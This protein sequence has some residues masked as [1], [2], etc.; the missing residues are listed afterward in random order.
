MINQAR[1]KQEEF[2]RRRQEEKE[3]KLRRE[4][5]NEKQE[6]FWMRRELEKTEKIEREKEELF[7]I[8]YNLIMKKQ[9]EKEKLRK[10]RRERLERVE[11]K[12]KE[13]RKTNARRCGEIVI[14]LV[15]TMVRDM[16]EKKRGTEIGGENM[17][18]KRKRRGKY[19]YRMMGVEKERERATTARRAPVKGKRRIQ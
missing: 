10:E 19:K 12:R 15:E 7:E 5:A 16:E 14:E 4:K 1:E 3:R 13:Q 18:R 6:E 11:I 8:C 17:L 2:T 9:E